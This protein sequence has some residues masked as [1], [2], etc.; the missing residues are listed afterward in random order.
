[1]INQRP[2]TCGHKALGFMWLPK[3][4]LSYQSLLQLDRGLASK[5]PT[6]HMPTVRLSK[7]LTIFVDKFR[8]LFFV[9]RKVLSKLNHEIYTRTKQNTNTSFSNIS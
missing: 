7:N 4:S 1:M 5:S 8:C 3:R 6:P 2:V 9:I